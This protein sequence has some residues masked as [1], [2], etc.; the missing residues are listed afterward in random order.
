[1]ESIVVDNQ[2]RKSGHDVYRYQLCRNRGSQFLFFVIW[3]TSRF[4]PVCCRRSDGE[5]E[6]ARQKVERL[7]EDDDADVVEG[8]EDHLEGVLA[9][10]V[11]VGDG[12]QQPG[13]VHLLF[14]SRSE[15]KTDCVTL[16]ISV[17][18]TFN[19]RHNLNY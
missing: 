4:E 16:S 1:M 9:L 3:L 5:A 14:L 18:F 12:L 11:V 15:D 2:V 10:V 7:E 13:V 17:L 6:L 19:L 8:Q